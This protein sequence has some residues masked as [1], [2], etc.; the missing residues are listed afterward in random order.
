MLLFTTLGLS[1][2][3]TG[4]LK[5]KTLA[6][7]SIGSQVIKFI[8]FFMSIF[9]S[10][11]LKAHQASF[12]RKDLKTVLR[13][14]L[15]SKS[16]KNQKDFWRKHIFDAD[17]R[18]YPLNSKQTSPYE[19]Q[20]LAREFAKKQHHLGFSWL[21]CANKQQFL[22][23][24]PSPLS[25]FEVRH[26][27]KKNLKPYCKK[28]SLDFAPRGLEK[29][30]KIVSTLH[31]FL[32]DKKK[33]GYLSLTCWSKE[34]KTPSLWFLKALGKKELAS[35]PGQEVLSKSQGEA[36]NFINWLRWIRKKMQLRKVFFDEN[37]LQRSVSRLFVSRS[38]RHEKSLLKKITLELRKKGF[39]LLG[40]NRVKAK[41]LEEALFSFWASA[42][43]RGLLLEAQATHA[44]YAIEL[45][46]ESVF[47]VF[48]SAKKE[49]KYL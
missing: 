12:E 43:H 49:I 44:A 19:L 11:T 38:I 1:I 20:N 5:D 9:F 45:K 2:L 3:E 30:Y 27:V 46:K 24:A 16:Q 31:K 37:L 17:L 26:Q 7:S 28:T 47:L 6:D 40:E 18:V 25:F 41:T 23:S 34:E 33:S 8:C 21:K 48:I 36:K 13:K 15:C 10:L 42:R 32:K 29:P 35:F 14:F 22:I 39:T 4:S